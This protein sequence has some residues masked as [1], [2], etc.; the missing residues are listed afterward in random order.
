MDSNDPTIKSLVCVPVGMVSFLLM[1]GRPFWP[2][3]KYQV[4]LGILKAS[5]TRQRGRLFR[6]PPTAVTGVA[7]LL[8]KTWQGKWRCGLLAMKTPT[9]PQLDRRS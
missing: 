3:N 4:G 5:P 7:S 1:A 6:Q 8:V 2:P 9:V